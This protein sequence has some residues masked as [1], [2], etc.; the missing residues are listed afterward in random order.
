[1]MVFYGI[2]FQFHEGVRA[3]WLAEKEGHV[4]KHPYDVGA[5]ENLT[6]VTTLRLF[7]FF[8]SFSFLA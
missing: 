7:S 3:M 1:M 5:Y 2:F 6:T 4:Y 8:L